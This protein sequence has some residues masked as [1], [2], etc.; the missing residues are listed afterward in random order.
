MRQSMDFF[1]FKDKMEDRPVPPVATRQIFT[2]S[3]LTAKIERTLHD[4]FPSTLHVRGE[5]SNF[6]NHSI[7][8]HLYFTLKDPHACI[9]CVM[10][11]S[12]AARLK[13][14]PADGLELLASGKL[15]VYGPRGRYQL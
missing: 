5:V 13:F 3:Q 15:A 7:S 4:A 9:E 11:K 6:K 12:D 10:Y 2:V 1:T 8:G 14:V